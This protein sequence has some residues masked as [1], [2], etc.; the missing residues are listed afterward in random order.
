MALYCGSALPR[1]GTVQGPKDVLV[2]A[3][4]SLLAHCPGNIC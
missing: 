3:L 4:L 2:G 1:G